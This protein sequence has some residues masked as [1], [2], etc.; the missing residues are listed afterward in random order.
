MK[1][2]YLQANGFIAEVIRT[3]RVKSADIKVANCAVSVVV[4]RQ[5]P[6][7]R[8]EKLLKDKNRWIKEKLFLQREALPASYKDYVS[9]EA[10]CYLGRN[11]RLKV[12]QGTFQP[13]KLLQGRLLVTVPGSKNQAHIT[14]N[15]LIRWYKHHAE[16]RL[17]D[18]V[19]RYAEIVGI[20]IPPTG[21]RSFKSRWGSCSAKGYI[22]F[23]WKIIMAPHPIV[24]YVVVHELCH[25]KQYDH[26]PKFWKLVE[27]VI[28]DYSDC[29]QWLKDN[30]RLFIL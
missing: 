15:A 4:P 13:V 5:L 3:S 16:L 11:Y 25:L 17:R 12:I 23:N 20:E 21:I 14:R 22:D 29:K 19:N 30:E 1:R 9:G 27:R 26:S 28:P 6:F 7:E 24:D 2:E 8:I 18:K 10:F